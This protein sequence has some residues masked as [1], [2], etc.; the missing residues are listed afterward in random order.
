[1]KQF[2]STVFFSLITAS[3]LATFDHGSHYGN[4]YAVKPDSASSISSSTDAFESTSTSENTIS[5]TEAPLS[6]ETVGPTDIAEDQFQSFYEDK[7]SRT[8]DSNEIFPTAHAMA[9]A[10]D[11]ESINGD[12]DMPGSLPEQEVLPNLESTPENNGNADP[13]SLENQSP[14]KYDYGTDDMDSIV[15]SSSVRNVGYVSMLMLFVAVF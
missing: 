4:V 8:D 5:P 13:F 3:V 2:S 9:E 14:P 15:L 10:T 1:M 7:E 12:P 6:L 11:E